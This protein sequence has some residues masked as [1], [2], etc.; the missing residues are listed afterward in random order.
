LDKN[1]NETLIGGD[2]FDLNW[3]AGIAKSVPALLIASGVFQYFTEEKIIQFITGIQNIF[4]NV[5]LIFDATNETGIKYANR[6]VRKTGN[7]NAM[8]YFYI[9]D[10]AEFAQKT[11]AVLIEERP[12]FTD[13]RKLL[14]K[15]LGLYTRIAMR[16]VDKGTSGN[17]GWVSRG[18]GKMPSEKIANSLLYKELRKSNFLQGV[19]KHLKTE[20]FRCSHNKKRAILLH[21]RLNSTKNDP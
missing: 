20:V 5:E 13:A 4:D 21:L 14:S 9:N 7:A 10:G 1:T 2:L 8:M 17:P 18:F 19:R 16:V 12:F 6:Y 11:G 3:T 15:K